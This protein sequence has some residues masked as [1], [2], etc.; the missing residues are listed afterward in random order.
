MTK[1]VSV[2]AI[3]RHQLLVAVPRQERRLS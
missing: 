1:V 3:P 2:V